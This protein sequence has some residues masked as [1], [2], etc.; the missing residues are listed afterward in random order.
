MREGGAEVKKMLMMLGLFGCHAFA[1]GETRQFGN[2]IYTVPTGWKIKTDIPKKDGFIWLNRKDKKALCQY[3]RLFIGVGRTK[4]G[5]LADFV[6][7]HSK[8]FVD[9]EDHDKIKLTTIKN[10]NDKGRNYV[11]LGQT[12]GKR[13]AQLLLGIELKDRYE[14]AAFQSYGRDPKQIKQN[15]NTFAKQG[16]P[17][18]LGFRFMS[19]GAKALMPKPIPGKLSGPYWGWK[20]IHLPSTTGGTTKVSHRTL[21]FWPDGLFY[22][23]T[24]PSGNKILNTKELYDLGKVEF[25]SYQAT[26]QEIKLAFA[27]GRQEI[28]KKKGNAW[29]DGGRQMRLAQ[30]VKDGTT[31]QGQ[32]KAFAYSSHTIG[33]TMTGGFSDSKTKYFKDGTYQGHRVGGAFSSGGNIGFAS[34]NKSSTGGKYEIRNGLL[35]QY[36][37]DNK[38][39]PTAALI[40]HVQDNKENILIGEEFLEE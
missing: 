10:L 12:I 20:M 24:P 35:I 9:Q 22:E 34:N 1:N 39:Q 5:S 19:E 8:T 36:P 23:G 38:G 30:F 7:S 27:D 6:K 4:T 32:V 21:I 16:L 31:I 3:C 15:L 28:L 26:S 14:I 25:G 29:S 2:I 13:H 11:L 33:N 18:M 17:F 40:L 37:K